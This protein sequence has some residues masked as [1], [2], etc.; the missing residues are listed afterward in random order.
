[1]CG[2]AHLA[3]IGLGVLEHFQWYINALVQFIRY[4]VIWYDLCQILKVLDRENEKEEI[5][6]S[7]T[8]RY[9]QWNNKEG[10]LE[11][12]TFSVSAGSKRRKISRH[13]LITVVDD[14]EDMADK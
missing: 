12:P 5:R 1:M 8:E 4:V 14:E 3:I 13:D 2:G 10:G 7:P 9:E 6:E 11:Y